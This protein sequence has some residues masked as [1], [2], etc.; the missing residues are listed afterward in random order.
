[1]DLITGAGTT[2]QSGN[3]SQLGAFTGSEN[4]TFALTGPNTFSSSGAGSLVA[5]NGNDLFVTTAGTGTLNGSAVAATTIYTIT[6]GT[7]RFASASGRITATAAGTSV[8]AGS[9]ETI[10]ASGLWNGVISY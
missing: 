3:L 2:D 4:A 10:T 8:S 1:V 6:G 5:A 9:T 7:G